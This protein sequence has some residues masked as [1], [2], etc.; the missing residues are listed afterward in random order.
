MKARFAKY[1]LFTLVLFF[2][3]YCVSEVVCFALLRTVTTVQK[4]D[5]GIELTITKKFP[6]QLRMTSDEIMQDFP[7]MSVIRRAGQF[8]SFEFD[9]VLGYKKFS[10]QQ[11][12]GGT[13]DDI[14]DKFLIV[15]FG[16][17]TTQLDNWPTYLLKYMKEAGVKQDAVVLNA[18]LAGYMTFNEKIYFAQWVLPMLEQA[19]KTPD[20]VLTMDGANDVWYRI[21]SWELARRDNVPWLD[22]YHGF[23]QHHDEDMRRLRSFGGGVRQFVAN[24]LSAFREGVIRVAPYTM[25]TLE[26]LARRIL[27]RD[28]GVDD[29]L[30]E[31]ETLELPREVEQRIV[32]GFRETLVDFYGL[33]AVRDIDFVAYLQPVVLPKYYPHTMPEEYP[34]KGIDWMGLKEYRSNAAFT[35]LGV[36]K[37]VDTAAMYEDAEQVYTDL[38]TRYPGHFTSLISLFKDNPDAAALYKNDSIHYNQAGKELLAKGVVTDL[39]NKGL[40]TVS[41]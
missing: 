29:A 34:F 4:E 15:C 38:N 11:W 8:L 23:H 37:L 7:S 36:N 10:N 14:R 41:P 27:A 24:S 2:F 6:A 20:L 40:V 22:R 18:G 9:P 16:G 33:A 13:I 21:M 30:P 12:Y 32:T 1:T 5:W 39:V 31:P 28:K 3:L 26:Y 35:R 17:S 19:G 25:R